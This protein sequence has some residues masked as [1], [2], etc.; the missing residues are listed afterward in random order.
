MTGNTSQCEGDYLVNE[1]IIVVNI[2]Y[3]LGIF[4]RTLKIKSSLIRKF[5]SNYIS[6]FLCT[7]DEE[8]YGNAGLKDQVLGLKWIYNNIQGFGGDKQRITLMGYSSGSASINYLQLINAT[9]GMNEIAKN[10]YY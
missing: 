5:I 1:N 9:E 2:H 7:H 8:A 4:G 3:R 6:G 10:N